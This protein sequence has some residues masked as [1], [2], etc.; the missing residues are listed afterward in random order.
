MTVFNM[1]IPDTV[2]AFQILGG[3]LNKNQQQT[4]L[5]LAS[6]LIFKSMK[7]ALK[8]VSGSENVE[9]DCN[10]DN[11]DYLDLQIKEENV[12]YTQLP[13][14]QKKG[15]FHPL[16]KQE[17]YFVVQFA[18]QKC[19]EQKTVNIKDLKQLTLQNLIK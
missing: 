8:R 17:L 9:K 10:C 11:Y 14:K 12:C 19:I 6:D 13:F 18:T 16:T 5:T 2:L 4:A 3:G 1:K 7:R 15:K